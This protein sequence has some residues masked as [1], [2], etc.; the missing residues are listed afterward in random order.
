MPSLVR[1]LCRVRI[2]QPIRRSSSGYQLSRTRFRKNETRTETSHI[3]RIAALSTCPSPLSGTPDHQLPVR[4]RI[5]LAAPCCPVRL[6][7]AFFFFC[8]II[9]AFSLSRL[10]RRTIYP[11]ASICRPAPSPP[12]ADHKQPL[13]RKLLQSSTV[14]IDV[15][16]F[17]AGARFAFFG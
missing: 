15:L 12:S 4:L 8:S 7:Q 10:W 5:S 2:P 14:S 9:L 16:E 11:V 6:H 1:Y 17:W 3:S 13:V